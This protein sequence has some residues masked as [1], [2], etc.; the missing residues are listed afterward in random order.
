MLRFRVSVGCGIDAAERHECRRRDGGG[1]EYGE[2]ESTRRE[3]ARI[4]GVYKEFA[5]VAPHRRGAGDIRTYARRDLEREIKAGFFV[6]M[7]PKLFLPVFE[8]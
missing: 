7:R 3:T 2:R 1:V 4:C 6:V 8:S 5:A